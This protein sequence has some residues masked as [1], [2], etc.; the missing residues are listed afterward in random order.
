[1]STDTSATVAPLS[2]PLPRRGDSETIM[3]GSR[4]PVWAIDSAADPDAPLSTKCDR[5]GR[6]DGICCKDL[7]DDDDRRLIDP[8]IVR[9]VFVPP[10]FPPLIVSCP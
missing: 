1:M 4:H 6:P 2:V 5:S 10:F 3:P 7:K 8:D 9:D